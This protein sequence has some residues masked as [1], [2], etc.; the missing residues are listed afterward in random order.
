MV[1]T[2]LTCLNYIDGEWLAAKSKAIL[3]S[4]NPADWREII[5]T[6]RSLEPTQIYSPNSDNCLGV[7]LTSSSCFTESLTAVPLS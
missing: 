4:R 2:P 5:A 3:E 7:N 6:F 1:T